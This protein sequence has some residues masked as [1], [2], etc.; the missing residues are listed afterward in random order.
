MTRPNYTDI[1]ILLDRSGSMVSIAEE[2]IAGVNQFLDD[3]RQL[4][5]DVTFSLIQFDHEFLRIC[6]AVPLRD[7]PGLS[8][9]TFVPRGNTALLDALG[10][11]VF[12]TGRRLDRMPEH[13]RPS[14]VLFAAFT[15]GC[16]NSSCTFDRPV[17]RNMILHQ[18]EKY[19]WEVLYLGANQNALAEASTLG[20]PAQ[21]VLTYA[22]TPRGA[23]LALCAL[24]QAALE[25]R[26][27][28]AGDGGHVPGL[29]SLEDF[30]NVKF[31]SAASV[32]PES[33]LR[34][35]G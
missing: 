31:P 25:F 29:R 1:T 16:E 34:R 27:N 32:T 2:T 21:N 5:G 14:L 20:I 33:E 9:S 6:E 22:A 18:R 3:Q 8:R 24:S 11:S 10:R 12:E 26:R 19:N 13:E 35:A 30:G 28:S 4:P 15:D 17:V 7:F 23:K